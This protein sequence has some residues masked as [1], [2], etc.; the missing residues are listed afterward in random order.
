MLGFM[1]VE[2]KRREMALGQG[3]YRVIFVKDGDGD[4]TE[5]RHLAAFDLRRAAKQQV[6]NPPWVSLAPCSHPKH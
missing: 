6:R 1:V 5:E 3:D 2:V 4:T